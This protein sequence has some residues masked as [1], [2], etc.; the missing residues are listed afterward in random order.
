MI[1][2]SSTNVEILAEMERIRVLYK[3]KHTMRY[4][5]SRDMTVHS[6]SVAEHLFAMQVI[7]QYFLPLEDPDGK[8]DRVRI[9]ELVLFHE[10]GEIE[11]GDILSARKTEAHRMIEK[12]AAARVITMLPQSMRTLAS[13]RFDEF[14]ERKTAEAIF[15]QA[16]DKLEPIFEMWDEQIAL[17][18][19]KKLNFTRENSLY[20]KI[21]IT[22]GFPYMRKFIE[23]WDARAVSLDTFP[24]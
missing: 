4:Q 7:A 3:L 10:I 22:D 1:S 16:V 14:E 18:L 13:E 15:A 19:F 21:A 6:E 23:A 24:S 20:G 9:N 8:L 17:P 12:E 11:T 2:L 5:S